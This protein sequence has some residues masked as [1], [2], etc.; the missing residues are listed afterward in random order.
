MDTKDY[1]IKRIDSQ[2]QEAVL[3]HFLAL[4]QESRYNR[5]CIS[6]NEYAL[7]SYVKQIN[8]KNAY[9]AV[10]DDELK[11]V[12]LGECVREKSKDGS[13]SNVAE[14][15]FSVLKEHQGKGLGNKILGRI[16]RYAQANSIDTLNMFCLRNNQKVVHL[17]K[18]FGLKISISEG[19]NVAILENMKANEFSPINELLE[20][21]MASFELVNK[22][23][24]FLMKSQQKILQNGLDNLLKITFKQ[25][26][27]KEESVETSTFKM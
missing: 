9:F 26:E 16:V 14:V 7:E 12:G 22:K 27:P 17:A 3:E 24:V 19:E 25:N 21:T 4:D 20:E 6:M 8:Y 2:Y 13:L 18:K 10:F 15:A 23:N 11:I 5:F 1:T